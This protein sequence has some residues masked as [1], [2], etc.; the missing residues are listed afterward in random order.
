MNE[1]MMRIIGALDGIHSELEQLRVLKE[2]ELDV[3]VE[4]A[5]AGHGPY[6]PTG[7]R[8]LYTNDEE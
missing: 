7:G 5:D 3:R 6:V 2:Y 4:H 1:L 8:K